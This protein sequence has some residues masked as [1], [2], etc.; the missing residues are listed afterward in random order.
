M[1]KIWQLQEAKARFSLLFNSVC[2][3]GPQRVTRRGKDT[4]VLI[5]E[6]EYRSLTGSHENFI[7]FLLSAPNAELDITR[8]KETGRTVEL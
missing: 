6:D 5:R 2:T 7:S 3:D 8:T 4:I 1:A